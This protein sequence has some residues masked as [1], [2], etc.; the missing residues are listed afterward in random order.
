VPLTS[1]LA[2]VALVYGRGWRRLRIAFPKRI[3]FWRVAAFVS[4]L[5]SLWIVFGSPLSAL[6]HDLLTIHMINHLVLMAIV[7]A[8][9]LA[10]APGLP[11]LRGLPQRFGQ[12]LYDLV[13]SRLPAQGLGR[14]LGHPV[15]AWLCATA[16]V[17]GWHLPAV[18][19]LALRSEGWHRFEYASFASAGLLF[20]WPVIDSV[21]SAPRPP[22]WS[23]PLYLFLA[24]LPCDILS[25]FLVFCGRV[26]YPSYLSAPRLFNFSAVQ[27]QQC[28][29]ALMW[30]SVT[31]AYLLPAVVITVQILSPQETH[32]PQPGLGMAQ[33]FPPPSLNGSRAEVV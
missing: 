18:F 7:P 25:G 14:V 6:D 32:S 12:G 24:T 23:M 4:G 2:L 33:S 3:P 22:R 21:S 30:V 11:L 16:T 5:F 31:F 19:Q 10:G 28:A 15:F 17:I 1:A 8:L 26:V 29:G 27:D 13:P 9:I 20:W